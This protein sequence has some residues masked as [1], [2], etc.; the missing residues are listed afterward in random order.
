MV[1]ENFLFFLS[2]YIL[3]LFALP[4]SVI[5]NKDLIGIWEMK[6]YG[7]SNLQ[8][9]PIFV[10]LDSI[11]FEWSINNEKMPDMFYKLDSDSLNSYLL[12]SETVKFENNNKSGRHNVQLNR[13]T[14]TIENFY[15]PSL[16]NLVEGLL[17]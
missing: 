13:D 6:I 9:Q 10:F 15:V 7:K 17:G 14:L 1:K 8:F 11:H 2:F 16:K 4:Q 3:P 12:F 5:S